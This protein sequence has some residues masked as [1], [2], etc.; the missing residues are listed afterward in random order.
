M[1]F[2]KKTRVKQNKLGGTGAGAVQLIYVYKFS[3]LTFDDINFAGGR[4]EFGARVPRQYLLILRVCRLVVVRTR[5]HR[6]A[7]RQ[8]PVLLREGHLLEV[9]RFALLVDFGVG[10]RARAYVIL[11]A[12]LVRLVVQRDPHCVLERP[13]EVLLRD[14]VTFLRSHRP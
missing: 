11:V 2:R 8:L 12:T 4:G 7:L 9:V 13:V 6:Q 10:G 1:F 14:A 5:V 3:R